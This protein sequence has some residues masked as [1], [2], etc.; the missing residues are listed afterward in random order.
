MQAAG[1]QVLY[2]GCWRVQGDLAVSRAFGDCHLKAY[3]VSATPELSAI[4]LTPRDA[5]LVLASDGIWGVLDECSG[6]D[7]AE[8]S[9]GVALRV[10]A[11]RAAGASAGD[12]AEGLVRCA[13]REG[14]TDNASCVVLLLG[15]RG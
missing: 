5:F 1:G 15:A 12:I 3:G 14:G 6:D 11:A 2:A 13:E 8:R 7:A 10:A 9:R 4:T